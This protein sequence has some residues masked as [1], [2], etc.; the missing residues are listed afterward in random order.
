MENTLPPDLEAY[1][2]QR[3]GGGAFVS[4]TEFIQEAVRRKMENDPWVEQKV[5]EAEQGELSPLTL[6]DLQS[7]R[8]SIRQPRATRSF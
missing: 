3:A 2:D 6:E 1:V 7:V 4:A 5:L 8:H